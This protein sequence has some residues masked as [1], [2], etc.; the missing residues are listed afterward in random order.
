MADDGFGEISAA[1]ADIS[2]A[3]IIS[4]APDGRHNGRLGPARLVL[5]RRQTGLLTLGKDR[6]EEAVG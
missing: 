6:T 1:N 3:Q 5:W 4:P 2:E